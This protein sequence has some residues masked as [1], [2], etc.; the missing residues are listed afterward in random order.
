MTQAISGTSR[1]KSL[2]RI[3]CADACN[4]R[5][6]VGVSPE[7]STGRVALVAPPGESAV[8]SPHE[9]R[10]LAHQLLVVAASL[11]NQHQDVTQL[12]SRRTR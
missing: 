5:R 3:P 9:A 6:T 4:R 7:S 10:A 12:D 8:M 1:I 11:D 2:T